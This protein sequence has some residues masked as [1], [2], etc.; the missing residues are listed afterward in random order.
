[1]FFFLDTLNVAIGQST[2]AL[3]PESSMV[4]GDTVSVPS[5][6]VDGNL[7]QTLEMDGP[8]SGR[9]LMMIIDNPWFLLDLGR[10]RY[11]VRIVIHLRDQQSK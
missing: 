10:S 4:I 5:L 3:L 9:C 2:R 1:M 7:G 11:I 8:L 6:A